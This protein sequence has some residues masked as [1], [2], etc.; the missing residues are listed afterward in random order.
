M[1]SK[2]LNVFILE[3]FLHNNTDNFILKI[4]IH[5]DMFICQM[6]M[7]RAGYALIYLYK[8]TMTSKTKKNN[9]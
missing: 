4:L 9:I 6:K 2:L 5:I 7:K 1:K 8:Y 3:T